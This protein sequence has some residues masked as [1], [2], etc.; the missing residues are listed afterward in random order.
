VNREGEIEIRVKLDIGRQADEIERKLKASLNAGGTGATGATRALRD[1]EAAALRLAQAHARLASASG[2]LNQ[3]ETILSTALARTTRETLTTINAQTQLARVHQQQDRAARGSAGG[4]DSLRASASR[5]Q[6]VFTALAAVGLV[7]LFERFGRAAFDAAIDVDKQVNSLKALT[8]SAEAAQKRF[9]ELFDLAQKTPGLTTS[10]AATLDAQLRIFS[11]SVQTIDK[12]LPVIGKLNA[13]SPLGDPRQFVNNLTQ[14]ITQNFERQDL[15]ELIG[16]SPIAGLLIKQIFN[17]DSPTNADAI[18]AAAKR[19]GI[20]TVESLANELIKAAENN[21]ALKNATESLG[22]Q[23][24][25]VRDRLNIALAPIGAEIAKTLIPAFDR[26][27]PKVQEFGQSLS[28][29][30]VENRSQIDR[31][32]DAIVD[33]AS[34][35]GQLG[36]ISIPVLGEILRVAANGVGFYADLANAIRGDFSFKNSSKNFG[37]LFESGSPEDAAIQSSP[38]LS[39]AE[40]KIAGVGVAAN[41]GIRAGATAAGTSGDRQKQKTELEKATQDVKE[42]A[43]K[44]A[45]LREGGGRLFEELAKLDLLRAQ[46]QILEKK[47][48]DRAFISAKTALGIPLAPQLPGGIG[49]PKLPLIALGVPGAIAG[50]AGIAE[51]PESPLSAAIK[52][53]DLADARLRIQEVQIQ[54]QLTTGTLSQAEAQRALNAVRAA[55]RGEIIAGLEAQ[56]K[57]VD[58]NSLEGLQ[59][60][61]QI[62][63]TR[64]LGVELSNTQRFMRGFGSA[65][66]TVGDAFERFGANVAR[67]FGNIRDLFNGLKQAVLG[68]FNDLLGNALQN[69]VRNTLGGLFGGGGSGGGGG[70]NDI[71]RSFASAAGGGISAPPSITSTQAVRQAVDEIAGPATRPR[72]VAGSAAGAAASGGGFSLG[73]LAGGLAAAAPLLGLSLGSSLGGRSS[74]GNILGAIGGGAIG[75][76]VAFGASVFGAGGGLAAAS[77]AALGPAALIGAPL[78]VGAILLGKASQRKKD[79]QASGEFLRQA[80][81][82]IDQLAAGVGSGQIEG[83]QARSIFDTQIL[84]TFRQQISGLK[85][86]SVVQSRLTNQ[87]RDLEAV[88]QA[89]IP[90]LI[91]EQIQRRQTAASNALAFSR[92]IP[93]FAIGGTTMGGLA[94]LHPGEKVLN[95]QQ[96]TAV[97]VMGGSNVFERAG[98]PGVQQNARFEG[99]GTFGG[100]GLPIEI[101]LE[102]QV[103]IGKGDA[104]RIVVVGASTPQGRAVTVNNVRVARTNREL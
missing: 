30:L 93:E 39:G 51:P 57:L 7:S 43:Q 103:I 76:G 96:Q 85:T 62:E 56:L 36:K 65:V 98:V 3:A 66:E 54:N 79:E 37:N 50:P 53:T 42:M 21:S 27:I 75:L 100:G 78:I 58:A 91:A 80:L 19:L 14:L 18:R 77:L 12:L 88:Y 20:T 34:A 94:F 99:G 44:V 83:S 1:Q 26:L 6:G 74:A 73:G 48:K 59:I 40:R 47:Q 33:L 61:A 2:G 89:R 71:F 72:T 55:S 49:P 16:Q 10:L 35:F 64:L 31:F 13:I 45:A 86:K 90:P 17:V 82:S 63:Q 84:A 95:L 41:A 15:K 60:A 5:L 97:R 46:F 81:A 101:T 8:G 38:F 11:V 68:F 9:K 87:V 22:G 92:Q 70:F 69:L 29:Y 104:T 52:R 102:A 25:K 28:R 4:L 67:A 23:F 32:T 24:D